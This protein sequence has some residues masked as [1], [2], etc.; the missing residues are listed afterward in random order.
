MSLLNETYSCNI[1]NEK[2]LH[3]D[4]KC[5]LCKLWMH[6]RCGGLENTQ[7][8][9][10]NRDSHRIW[11]NCPTLFSF[12]NVNDNEFLF[13]CSSVD[14]SS[15]LLTLHD[16][17]SN[18]SIDV[19]SHNNDDQDKHDFTLDIDPDRNF[20]NALDVHC[21]YYTD[22]Q[23]IDCDGMCSGMSIFNI[24]CRSMHRNFSELHD[25]LNSLL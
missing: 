22:A 2:L 24:N 14:I 3:N 23:F 18:Y 16:E 10:I 11:N 15:H 7:R 19:F 21:G 4:I 6:K 20:Y 12:H 17:C 13:S 1:C 25:Y 9:I 8:N 5:S